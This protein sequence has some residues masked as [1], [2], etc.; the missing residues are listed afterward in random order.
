LQIVHKTT[1][2]GFD[3]TNEIKKTVGRDKGFSNFNGMMEH[4]FQMR[5]PR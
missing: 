3:I 4:E 1:K 5:V 2:V